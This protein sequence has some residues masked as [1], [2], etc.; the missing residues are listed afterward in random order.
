LTGLRSGRFAV[1]SFTVSSEKLAATGADQTLLAL[2]GL[3][4]G[5]FLVGAGSLQLSGRG[6]RQR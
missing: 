4:A 2:L 1:V 5:C 6:V 3:A